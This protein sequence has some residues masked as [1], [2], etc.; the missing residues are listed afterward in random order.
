MKDPT[1]HCPSTRREY[2]NSSVRVCGRPVTSSANCQ[3]TLYTV[4]HQYNN[5]CGR[6]IGYQFATPD[7]FFPA[8]TIDQPYVD[9]VSVTYG[10]PRNHIWTFAAGVTEE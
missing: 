1:Q 5:V 2:A 9:G 3:P 6:V 7:G 8:E 10:A 4:G